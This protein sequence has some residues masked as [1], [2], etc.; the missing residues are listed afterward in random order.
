MNQETK[1]LSASLW[2]SLQILSLFIH[3]P[4]YSIHLDNCN[5]YWM[6]SFYCIGNSSS[7]GII[8]FQRQIETAKYLNNQQIKSN[9]AFSIYRKVSRSHYTYIMLLQLSKCTDFSISTH[10]VKIKLCIVA[11]HWWL[12]KSFGYCLNIT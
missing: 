2:N 6:T 5:T 4:A 1:I 12:L 11:M 10:L 3:K 7:W 8:T 9:G